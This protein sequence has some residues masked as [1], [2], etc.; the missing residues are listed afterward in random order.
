MPQA[1]N[2][3]VVLA[4]P[5]RPAARSYAAQVG[6]HRGLL[7]TS[8]SLVEEV[9]HAGLAAAL[10]DTELTVLCILLSK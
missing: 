9:P 6:T 7:E 10:Q 3:E 1:D 8:S 5:P 2:T 4:A